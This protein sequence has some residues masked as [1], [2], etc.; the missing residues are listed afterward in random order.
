M[1]TTQ[2][3]EHNNHIAKCISKLL[4]LNDYVVIPG[5]GALIGNYMPSRLHPV[6]HLSQA[7]GK[8]LVFN[9]SL[10]TDDG[11]LTN[12]VALQYSL[13]FKESRDL[14]QAYVIHLNSRLTQG[15]RIIWN[16]LGDLKEDVERN[17]VFSPSYEIN[18]LPESFGLPAVQIQLISRTPVPERR[19]EM[20]FINREVIAP[21]RRRF[22]VLKRVAQIVPV[23]A[24]AALLTVNSFLPD[25]S[26]IHM[27]D[28]SL[29]NIQSIEQSEGIKGQSFINL[30]EVRQH[31]ALVKENTQFDTDNARVF[32][33][34]GC[35]SNEANAKGMVDYLVEKGFNS[36]ILDRTPG[37]LLRVVYDEYADVSSA[38]EELNL[39]KKGFNEQ[40]WMLIR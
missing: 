15:E 38:A 6:T 12:S 17:L 2:F 21:E 22:P 14:I 35:Y 1:D 7:P 11:L 26:R 13:T 31:L 28:L 33:V 25:N 23:L 16:G 32:L 29:F 3:K 30:P 5:F 40:A 27:S 8:Q 9:R 36:Y 37:G 19:P 10:K 24:I 18:F 39:I 20:E 34:A 4:M